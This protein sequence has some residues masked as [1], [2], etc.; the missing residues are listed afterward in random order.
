MEFSQVQCSRTGR[1]ILLASRL[2][3]GEGY[4]PESVSNPEEPL[5]GNGASGAPRFRQLPDPRGTPCLH[6]EGDISTWEKW[7]HF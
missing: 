1:F 2:E 6:A 5:R 3:Q 4:P 7:G